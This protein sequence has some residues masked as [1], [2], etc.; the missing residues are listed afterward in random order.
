MYLGRIIGTLWATRK[1]ETLE[2]SK[3]L[4]L[5]PVNAKYEDVGEAI[6]AVDTIGAGEGEYVIYVDDSE[7]VIPLPVDHAPVNASI[8]GIVDSVFIKE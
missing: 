6:V 7:A 2:G 8:V 1:Y 3:L 5:Q 4:L